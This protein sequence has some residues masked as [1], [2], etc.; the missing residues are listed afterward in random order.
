[1]KNYFQL[2]DNP[3]C[4]V[5]AI[6]LKFLTIGTLDESLPDNTIFN[7]KV[8]N[9]RHPGPDPGLIIHSTLSKPD[10]IDIL[11]SG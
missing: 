5:A 10:S 7:A 9:P 6:A 11:F 4:Y 2:F 3:S 8:V 1:M